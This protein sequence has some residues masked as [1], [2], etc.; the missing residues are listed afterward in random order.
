[1]PSP[2]TQTTAGDSTTVHF[3]R[4]LLLGTLVLAS[5]GTLTEL[6]LIG[7]IE[8]VW[9]LIPVGLLTLMLLALASWLVSPRKATIR[10][11]QTVAV[12]CIASGVIGLVQHYR[13]NRAF[14][15]EMYP[16]L[17]GWDL[18]WESLTGATPALAPGA[19]IQIGLVAIAYSYRHPRTLQ[20]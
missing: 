17:G 7:H 14:E 11:V 3:I 15:L 18:V 20:P 1:M 12:T 16:D 8:S 10:G 6:L 9:Q 19:M 2:R 13:G 4:R 5:A